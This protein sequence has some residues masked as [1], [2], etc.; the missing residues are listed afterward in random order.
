MSHP[1]FHIKIL[2]VS[3]FSDGLME[4]IQDFLYAQFIK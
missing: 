2:T 4:N 1:V 3:Y